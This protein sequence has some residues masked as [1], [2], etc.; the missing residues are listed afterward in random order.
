MPRPVFDDLIHQPQRLQLCG[1]L[2]RET[3]VDFGVLREEMD[4][5]DSALSKHLKL[6]AEAGYVTTRRVLETSRLHT[7]A[8]LTLEGREALCGHVAELQRL[9]QIVSL[10]GGPPPRTRP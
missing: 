8:R 5:S 10:R 6:L 9:A 3:E 4:L 2:A 1:R 7:R